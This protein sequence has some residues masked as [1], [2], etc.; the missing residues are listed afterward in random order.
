MPIP[1]F[2]LDIFGLG[3]FSHETAALLKGHLNSHWHEVSSAQGSYL[4]PVVAF[5]MALGF[6]CN[7]GS[8]ILSGMM[9]VNFYGLHT[10]CTAATWM[11]LQIAY[12]C[13]YRVKSA[14]E[15]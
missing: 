10:H 5:C 4:C 7:P 2:S 12:L 15:T 8:N 14:L 11:R 3:L 9:V 1:D 13:V 6:P